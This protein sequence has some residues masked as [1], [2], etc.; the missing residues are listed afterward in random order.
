MK[1]LQIEVFLCRSDN[2]GVLLHCAETGETASIDAPEL[3]PIVKAAEKR[4]WKITHVFTTHHHGDHVE[5][6]LA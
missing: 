6:N 4:G 5:A 1:S 2:F 3:D